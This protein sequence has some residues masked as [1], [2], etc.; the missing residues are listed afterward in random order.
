MY[1]VLGQSASFNQ[2]FE[3]KNNEINRLIKLKEVNGVFYCTYDEPII[4][5]FYCDYTENDK[6]RK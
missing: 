6:Y 1:N 5:E 4:I 3:K 2:P